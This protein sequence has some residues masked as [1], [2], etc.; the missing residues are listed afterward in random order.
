MTATWNILSP[1]HTPGAIGLI[2]VA[3]PSA[4]A[5]ES[6]L[7]GAGIAPVIVGR[8]ALRDL[9]GIDRGIVARWTHNRCLLMPHGG[10]ELM[11]RLTQR[12]TDCGIHHATSDTPGHP[13]FPEAPTA[14]ESRMLHALANA[15]SPLAIDL[16]LDQPR[17]WIEGAES[18]PACDIIL[19]RL[20]NPP[21]VV[22][23][24]APNIGKSTLINALSGRE[25]SIVADAPGTTRDHV[26][27]MLN[28]SGLVVRYLDTPGLRETSDAIEAEAQTL[29]LET[30]RHADLVLRLGDASAAAP[31]IIGLTAPTLT[32][33]LRAD[34][35]LPRWPHDVALSAR[36]GDGLESLVT[37]IRQSLVPDSALESARP[38]RF[39][40]EPVGPSPVPRD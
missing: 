28:L 15:A 4:Q 2:E 37:R 8:T 29:S 12:L 35:G 39:W 22:A 3:A 14:I 31:Q 30:A 16:L 17:R 32:V 18:D 11:R 33:A 38:W 6:A 1:A 23:M 9:A 25:V 5:L 7:R 34:L 21:L 27:V 10:V 26:G 36:T 13:E 20:L 19:H 40:A 24:G